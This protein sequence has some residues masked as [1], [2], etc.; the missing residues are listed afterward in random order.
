MEAEREVIAFEATPPQEK[1]KAFYIALLKTQFT[2]IGEMGF[3]GS[4]G[5]DWMKQTEG[6][7]GKLDLTMLKTIARGAEFLLIAEKF[8][9]AN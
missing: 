7:L 2:Q 4:S 1:D 5:A 3:L 9:A 6:A 8:P